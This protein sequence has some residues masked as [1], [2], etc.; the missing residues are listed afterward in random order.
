MM[1]TTHLLL[2]F[3]SLSSSVQ[4]ALIDR[5][6]GLLYDDVLNVTWLQ[7]A[8]YAKT[9][10]FDTTGQ[11]G[12]NVANNWAANLVYHDSIRNMDYSDW[13]LPITKPINGIAF[14]TDYSLDTST[15]YGNVYSSQSEMAWMFYHNLGLTGMWDTNGNVQANNGIFGNGSHEAVFGSGGNI[16]QNN[17]G[18]VI[19]L[20]DT[21]YWTG[22]A[23]NNDP[24]LPHKWDFNMVN[25][26]Q[27][28]HS[29]PNQWM[30][31]AVRDGD[32]TAVPV[33]GAFWLFGSVMTALLG[34]NCY[35]K[36]EL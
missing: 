29:I 27:R 10:G 26:T 36:Q 3:L 4:A 7:D 34:I 9:S 23:F 24:I 28:H 18:L 31:W 21:E 5:G 13:R 11:M 16:N 12:W 30:A 2:F 19:N 20:Q 6:G 35:K 25:G 33:P 32:V 17:V 22:T 1:K 14:L 8:N 15:D